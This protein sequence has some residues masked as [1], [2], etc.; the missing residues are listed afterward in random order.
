MGLPGLLAYIYAFVVAPFQGV[1]GGRNDLDVYLRAAAD[2]GAGRDPYSDFASVTQH[3]DPTLTGG[4]IY[5]PGLAWYLQPLAGLP[6]PV[7]H[8]L[9]AVVL[10]L[11]LVVAV[12]AIL[13]VVGPLPRQG[14]AAIGVL[15]IGFFPLWQ[16]LVYQQVNLLL[17]ALSA[18][19]LVSWVAAGEERRREAL[20]ALGAGIAVAIKL[21]QAPTLALVV[22]R[23]RWSMLGPAAIGALAVLGAGLPWLGE[24]VSRVMPRVG[25][26]T[27]WV[28]NQAP[29]ALA[30]RL[31]HPVSFYRTTPDTGPEVAITAAVLAVVVI[32]LTARALWRRPASRRDRCL[33]VA[34]VVSATPVF[35]PL[36]WDTH[37]VLLILP[38]I[39]LVVDSQRRGDDRGVAAAALAWVLMGPLHI[40]YLVVFGLLL[41]AGDLNL[42]L[43]TGHP[44]PAVDV[45]L[46][47]G[48]ELGP[49]GI[50]VLWLACLRA[51]ST[52]YAWSS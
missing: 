8:A 15:T 5:P 46:R 30:A 18:G 14:I 12:V 24:Y 51:Y 13:R 26:G 52:P 41:Q 29:A 45:V 22:W 36:T 34:L 33:E 39:V 20:G 11:L 3:V 1:G 10:Q 49:V 6:R 48:A 42:A 50:V 47:L 38:L 37:L 28:L 23:R 17:L 19:F 9:V 40:A 32:G 25:Q 7:A 43:T 4:Y 2:M 31:V 35:L 44:G 27:G 21:I 16:N